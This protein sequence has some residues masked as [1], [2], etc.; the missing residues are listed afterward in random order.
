MY[1]EGFEGLEEAEKGSRRTY[2]SR[3]SQDEAEKLMRETEEL[4][5][6]LEKERFF[7][8][9]LD[10]EIQ[11]LKSNNGN[12]P[13]PYI[14][15]Y[16]YGQR[17]VSRGAFY[18]LLFIT[19]VMAA[20]IGYGFYKTMKSD[21]VDRTTAVLP[22]TPEPAKNPPNTNAGRKTN[23]AG[24]TQI[25]ESKASPVSSSTTPPIVKDSVPNIIAAKKPAVNKAAE[26][27][28]EIAEEDPA[29]STGETTSA[30]NVDTRPVIAQ[31]HVT[32]KANF[33]N[34]AD[35]NTMRN[36]FISRSADKIVGA[37]EE[38]N[39]FIYVV[40]TNDLGYTTKGWLSKKD[41]TKVE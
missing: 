29:S 19:L 12:T 7:N 1:T 2:I 39:G 18:T 35:E 13:P 30:A 3:I 5:T 21:D 24:Q 23:D 14:S 40:Y 28:E 25:T 31:Y 4:K 33:Y 10:K 6:L 36:I 9:L 15:N 26:Q 11:E 16:W 32:S 41:L 8:K 38:K 27:P 34:D 17:T 22:A 37:L 20:Y